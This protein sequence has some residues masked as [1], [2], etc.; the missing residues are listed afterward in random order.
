MSAYTIV[1]VHTVKNHNPAKLSDLV[2]HLGTHIRNDDAH[3]QIIPNRYTKY[4]QN[5]PNNK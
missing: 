1:F 5:P 3:A 4:E 2:G